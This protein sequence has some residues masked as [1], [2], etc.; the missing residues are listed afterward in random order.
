MQNIILI[1]FF[2]VLGIFCRYGIDSSAERLSLSFPLSTF[3]INILG[4]FAAGLIY[5]L[6]E[7]QEISPVIQTSL[8]VGFCGGFTTFSAYALQTFLMIEKGRFFPAIAYLSVTPLLGLLAAYFPIL[9]M[10]KL[11]G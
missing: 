6:G 5:A 4:S 10:R 2:G 1:G 8:L 11:L 9:L 7:R 3:A